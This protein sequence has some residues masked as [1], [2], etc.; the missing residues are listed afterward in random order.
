MS[1]NVPNHAKEH[2]ELLQL[3]GKLVDRSELISGC[4]LIT[5]GTDGRPCIGGNMTASSMHEIMTALGAAEEYA[6]PP[7]EVPIPRDN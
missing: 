5:I 3:V 7:V 4:I 6:K 1:N 2:H